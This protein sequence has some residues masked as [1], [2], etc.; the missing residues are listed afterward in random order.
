VTTRALLAG[1]LVAAASG[2]DKPPDV[3]PAMPGPADA[4]TEALPE[5]SPRDAWEARRRA[6]LAGDAKAVWESLCASSRA[7][8][9]RTQAKA[10]DE[11]RRLDDDA[12]ARALRP[13]GIDSSRFRRM[14]AEEFCLYMIGGTSQ[15]SP[16]VKDRMKAQ[17]FVKS[18][19]TGR[20][21][22]CTIAA[23]GESPEPLVMVAEGGKWKLDDTATAKLRG[24]PPRK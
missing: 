9:L 16:Q 3:P 15:V 6:W 4:S 8:K 5:S 11:M 12:L 18:E 23:P 24:T 21:A 20:T 14:T 2:C 22:V 1:I 7:D 17:E 13:Y 10:M 19:V